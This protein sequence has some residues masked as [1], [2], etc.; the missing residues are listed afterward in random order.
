MQRR[1]PAHIRSALNYTIDLS[2]AYRIWGG[3][4]CRRRHS[5]LQYVAIRAVSIYIYIH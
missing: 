4:R 2:P 1:T 5:H 3:N